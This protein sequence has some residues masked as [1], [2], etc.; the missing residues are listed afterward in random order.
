MIYLKLHEYINSKRNWFESEVDFKRFHI[1][2]YN[3]HGKPCYEL[4]KFYKG[5]KDRDSY[6]FKVLNRYFNN[7]KTKLKSL[8]TED[9]TKDNILR[10]SV[11][12]TDSFNDANLEFK[13]L[14][15]KLLKE[16]YHIDVYDKFLK[17]APNIF[18]K[19][20]NKEYVMSK[21]SELIGKY[22]N[23]NETIDLEYDYKTTIYRGIVSDVVYD[24]SNYKME[25][26]IKLKGDKWREVDKEQGIY[27][28]EFRTNTDKYN[29]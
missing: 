28:S 25:L 8:E 22:V 2:K 24:N 26:F 12:Q 13:K 5:D 9:T 17:G 16:D 11:Y 6:W 23:F 15:S 18:F 7:K 4:I 29:L 19:N 27:V 21:F 10:M 14:N 20:T 3:R 1:I